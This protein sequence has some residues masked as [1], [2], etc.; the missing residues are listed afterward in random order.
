VVRGPQVKEGG[1]GALRRVKKDFAAAA[2]VV[3]LSATE[4]MG[5][6]LRATAEV[7]W[8]GSLWRE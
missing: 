1:Y 2:T 5:S 7:S 8:E 3:E 4:N 6:S